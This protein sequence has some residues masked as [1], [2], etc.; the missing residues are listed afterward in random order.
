MYSPMPDSNWWV[1]NSE[2]VYS[3]ASCTDFRTWEPFRASPLTPCLL[4][5]AVPARI[6]S[7]RFGRGPPG[8]PSPGALRLAQQ[9]RLHHATRSPAA[10]GTTD[11][12]W[13]AD[14]RILSRTILCGLRTSVFQVGR[15]FGGL[16]LAVGLV[17]RLL[18]GCG[19]PL[20]K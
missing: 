20:S 3:R 10:T 18:L 12:Q 2:L 1:L 17:G 6:R 13:A 8:H 14:V 19:R 9:H 5:A 7:I 4:A 16:Q 15:V 11:S